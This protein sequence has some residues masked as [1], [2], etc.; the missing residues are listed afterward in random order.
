MPTVLSAAIIITPPFTRHCRCRSICEM[1]RE[2][3]AREDS[4]DERDASAAAR[5]RFTPPMP[6]AIVYAS[7]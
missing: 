4:G 7:L 1:V 2:Y 5:R 3:G 6:A